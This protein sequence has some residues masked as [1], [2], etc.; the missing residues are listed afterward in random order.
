MV[1]YWSLLCIYSGIEINPVR[2]CD[3]RTIGGETKMKEYTAYMIQ[4]KDTIKRYS[5]VQ[6][7][8]FYTSVKLIGAAVSVALVLLGAFAVRT[9]VLSLLLIF[10]GC[11]VFTNL[12]APANYTANRVIALFR[13]KFPILHYSFSETGMLIEGKTPEVK[14]SGIIR[15]VEDEEYLYLFQ[16]PQYGSMIKKSSVSGEDELYGL[17][18]FLTEKTQL[19]WTRPP[20]ILNFNLK[21]LRELFGGNDRHAG[22]R[23]RR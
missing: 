16:S 14:Y 8:V 15:L 21:S 13:G 5:E 22:P 1:Y 4:S 18:C 3:R 2:Q 7:D 9:E 23:L 19:K 10:L 11:V 20:T 12:N 6:F 17:K